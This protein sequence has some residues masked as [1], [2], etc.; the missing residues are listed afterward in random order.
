MGVYIFIF[1][2]QLVTVL[3]IQT[4]TYFLLTDRSLLSLLPFLLSFLSCF[5]TG[6]WTALRE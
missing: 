6:A 2:C 1:F 5:V 3:S 4:F